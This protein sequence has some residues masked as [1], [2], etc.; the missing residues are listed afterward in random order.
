MTAHRREEQAGVAIRRWGALKCQAPRTGAKHYLFFLAIRQKEDCMRATNLFRK[1]LWGTGNRRKIRRQLQLEGLEERTLLSTSPVATVSRTFTWA[2][3]PESSRTVSDAGGPVI[4]NVDV[5]L[6]FW[7]A[8]WLTATA[9]KQNVTNSVKT[10]MN[11]PYLS[12]LAQYRGIGN[13]Q[14]LRTDTIT[15][16][17]PA[18]QT[19]DSQFKAFVQ[20]NINNGGLPVTPNM[21]NQILYIV[22]PPPGT[23][24]PQESAAGA[25]GTDSSN[26]GRFHYGWTENVNDLDDITVVYSHELAESVT[27]PEANYNKAFDVPS[28]H[29]EIGDGVAQDY[30]YR[31]N[32]ILVQSFL[33]QQDHAYIGPMQWEDTFVVG[34]DGAINDTVQRDGS[35]VSQYQLEPPGTAST[36]GGIAAVSRVSNAMQVWWIGADGSVQDRYFWDP[37]GWNSNGIEILAPA[38][39]ASTTGGITAVSRVPNAM[40]VWWIGA[41]GSVQNRYFWDGTGWNSNGVEVIAGPG[42]ASTTG[43]ITAVSR[44]PE[45]MEVWWIGVDGSVKDWY[46]WDGLRH[47]TG[48]QLAGPE[49]A[50]TTGGITAITRVPNH[51]EVWW[52]GQN[53]SVQDWYFWDS[54]G[55]TAS[56]LAGAGSASTTGGI[57]AVSRDPWSMEV[58][59][60]GADG[61]VQDK[62]YFD[63]VG[64]NGFQLAPAGS[65][66]TTSGVGAFSRD[67]DIMEVWWVA[68]D[69]SLQYTYFDEWG[70]H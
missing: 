27:D 6:V 4:T 69:G 20:A 44:V 11:S 45:H 28:T 47:W 22:I 40:Q 41:D 21:D 36:T 42:S 32:G 56:E 58:W 63:A 68:S 31:L 67:A 54:V 25:H 51:M 60:I 18:A 48:T 62:Y 50:S 38:G 30:S 5:D 43:G 16:T 13:G 64:W 17:D 29:D 14:L 53:G 52:I 2:F 66:S 55:W 70:W 19:T 7:G 15:S 12:G 46:W 8:G 1:L 26:F 57:A 49:S 35:F 23:T 59:W 24:D 39:T 33:S 61:S 37:V 3:A 34:Q 65:A 10:I 9:L